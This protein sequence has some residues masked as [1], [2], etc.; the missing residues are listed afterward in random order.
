MIDAFTACCDD[1][2]C[3]FIVVAAFYGVWRVFACCYDVYEILYVLFLGKNLRFLRE[4]KFSP[5]CEEAIT[6]H[7]DPIVGRNQHINKKYMDTTLLFDSGSGRGCCDPG[8]M[9]MLGANGGMGGMLPMMAMMGGGM[10]GF[11]G[12]MWNN[13]IWAIVFLAA[14]QNGG[15]FGG[16]GGQ[17]CGQGAQDIEIQG[18]LSAIRE[19]LS[20]NQNTSLLM[21]AIKG[22]GGAV[23]ELASVINCDFN[24]V[25][26]A[27]NSVQ[28]AICNLGSKNDMNAM[29]T[30]NAINS[31]N[32]GLARQLSECCC[33]VREEI[34]KSNYENQLATVNQT[35]TLQNSLNFVNSSVERGFASTA[36]E[37]AQQ[38][39]ELKNAIAAQTQVIND[40]FC[41]LEMREMARENRDL[42]DQ[43]Q[44]YQLS[45]SQLAQ[46]QSIVSQ[47]RP[48]PSPAYV[49]P[50]P[51]GCGCNNFGYGYGNSGCGGCGGCN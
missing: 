39:C 32:A 28:S 38:T 5:C 45:E 16:R 27:I 1:F 3:L 23:R 17:G 50:N 35:N 48:C 21:D 15:L 11:G 24:A 9:A 6:L 42:R 22:N 20:T 46:T 7:H 41:Q 47:V 12:G 13:P 51:Y 44:R 36:Y 34:T 33:T 31:G 40:K 43:V 30:I 2:L 4:S 25:Q 37:T 14:L 18:Q 19:T 8:L 10:G 49:V 26:A 29:Q